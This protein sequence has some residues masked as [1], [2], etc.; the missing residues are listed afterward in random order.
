MN[1]LTWV[2]VSTHE[3]EYEELFL[4]HRIVQAS[5]PGTKLALCPRHPKTI[6]KVPDMIYNET[7]GN[8]DPYFQ[9]ADIVFV[10]GTFIP[11]GGHNVL[12]PVSYKKPT[13][14]GPYTDKIEDLIEACGGIIR[15]QNGEELGQ[16]LIEL[17]LNASKR[18]AIADAC[19]ASF[20]KS[21]E[22]VLES[23][24][25]LISPIIERRMSRSSNPGN[26]AR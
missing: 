22:G 18:Q 12:E 21:R 16:K 10:G 2:A 17:F 19:Y 14:V 25:D 5:L 6:S 9:M 8:M 24:L 1:K 15:V 20:M 4:A 3:G 26:S 7:L 23:Y 13:L 11:L